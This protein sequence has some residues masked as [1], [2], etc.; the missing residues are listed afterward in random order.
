MN[1]LT[2]YEKNELEFVEPYLE[3]ISN[4]TGMDI[5]FI[6]KMYLDQSRMVRENIKNGKLDP[7]SVELDTNSIELM[8]K[9]ED[10]QNLKKTKFSIFKDENIVEKSIVVDDN[11][12]ILK[13]GDRD[14][15]MSYWLDN[16]EKRLKVFDAI[17]DDNGIISK[18]LIIE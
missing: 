13:E 2:D 12:I 16:I 10:I 1:N 15:C 18:N 7:N 3:S 5:N 6:K 8:K 11:D 9:L 4:S 14:S 17:Y